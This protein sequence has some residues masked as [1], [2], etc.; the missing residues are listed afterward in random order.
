MKSYKKRIRL[1]RRL[2]ITGCLAALVIPA[3]AS[4]ML[5][6]DPI[7]DQGSQQQYT[8]PANFHPEVQT[9]AA[10]QS[11]AHT[12]VLRRSFKPEV[13]TTT[14]PNSSAPTPTVV[15]QIETV[16]DNSGRTLAI[17]LAAVALAV[18]IGSLAY[19]AIR[20]TQLQRRELGSH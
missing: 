2:A 9:A 11:P 20:M 3:S 8:L 4:A 5:P 13:Q 1:I 16:S 7:S 18:A 19:A 17:V 14:P 15:R 10:V 6:K 12:F